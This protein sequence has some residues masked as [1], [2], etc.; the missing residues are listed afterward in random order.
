MLGYVE[1]V[2]I[3]LKKLIFHTKATKGLQNKIDACKT[4]RS[5]SLRGV[6]L[7]QC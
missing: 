3:Y 6:C 2:H 5:V 4:L 1:I 7:A